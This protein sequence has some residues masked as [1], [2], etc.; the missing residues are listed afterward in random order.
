MDKIGGSRIYLSPCGIGLGHVGR[1]LPIANELERN[2]AEVM[3]STYLDGV[4]YVRSQ[5]F[6]VVKSPAIDFSSDS[7]GRVD[8]KATT[9]THGIEALPKFMQQI[10]AEIEYMK[11]F[12][13]NVVVSD[14]RLSTV[15]AAKLL[16]LPVALIINQFRLMVPMEGVHRNISRLV[17]GSLMTLLGRGW[18]SSDVII[19][20]DFPPPYTICLD[21]LRIP[22]QY[23]EKVKFVGFILEKKPEEVR[24]E[25]VRKMV[26]AEDED[27]L[28]Y[29]AIS[30]PSR[31]KNPLIKILKLTFKEFPQGFKIILSMG[32]PDGGSE[33]NTEG[34]L[35]MIPWVQERFQYIK[36]SDIVVCRG[37]H[38]TIMQAI[39]YQKPSIIIPTPNHTEQYANARRASE[40]GLAKTIHQEETNRKTLMVSVKQLLSDVGYRERLRNITSKGLANGIHNTVEILNQLL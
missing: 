31:E 9:L 17:D 29:A 12:K 22:K 26:G 37:G 23:E 11:A 34:S 38:N 30:G 10:T 21:S 35:T 32:I 16:G 7:T 5:G 20:P 4:E 28:I 40:L 27:K 19:I 8:L 6:P 13:P 18:G 3:F 2:G 14:S 39:S 25:K 24:E 33:S 1:I 15:I 36:A